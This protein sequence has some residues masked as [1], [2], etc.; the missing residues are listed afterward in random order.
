MD[1]LLR[2]VARQATRQ[3]HGIRLVVVARVHVDRGLLLDLGVVNVLRA[4]QVL[5]RNHTLVV[6]LDENQLVDRVVR[7][8]AEDQCFIHHVVD[9]RRLS[10]YGS[11]GFFRRL[12]QLF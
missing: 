11:V 3:L 6:R 5:E 10:F 4:C 7:C 2:E 8:R 12:L 9:D 1:W